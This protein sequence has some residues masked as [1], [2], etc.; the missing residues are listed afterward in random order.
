MWRL[1]LRITILL[2]LCATVVAQ[3]PPT[4]VSFTNVNPATVT[5]A[6]DAS[7]TETVTGY[8]LHWGT[9]SGNYQT[10]VDTG[11]VLQFTLLN[12][13][14]GIELFFV[15]TA[16]D[17][18][19]NESGYSNEVSA[20]LSV[21]EGPPGPE[22]PEGPVGPVGPIGPQG[23][24]G[25]PGDPGSASQ[26][27]GP[28]TVT[29]TSKTAL[30]AWKTAEPATSRIEYQYPGGMFNSLVVNTATVTDHTVN[31]GSLTGGKVYTYTV[32][33]QTAGGEV[34]Q[35]TGTFRTR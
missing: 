26:V 4:S 31:L 16:Y 18:S 34:L 6:W 12:M 14:S 11:D 24:K 20:T 5:L 9:A 30:L 27:Q 23:P 8:K 15:A 10:T 32:I 35:A 13:P 19:G 29:V 3:E 7:T 2:G 22:G 25:D 33:N 1:L 21:P 28:C 17:G